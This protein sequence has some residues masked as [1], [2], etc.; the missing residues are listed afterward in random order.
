MRPNNAIT[1]VQFV[2]YVRPE[3][4]GDNPPGVSKRNVNLQRTTRIRVGRCVPPARISQYNNIY[5][6]VRCTKRRARQMV[7]WRPTIIIAFRGPG[8]ISIRGFY[9]RCKP[10]GYLYILWPFRLASPGIWF[11]IFRLVFE[12]LAL[13]GPGTRGTGTGEDR[14][15]RNRRVNRGRNRDKFPGRRRRRRGGYETRNE[16]LI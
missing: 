2:P 7:F 1:R 6:I 10:I 4:I 9:G 11:R 14:R 13:T 5:N 8:V 15:I 3:R 16:W 12:N